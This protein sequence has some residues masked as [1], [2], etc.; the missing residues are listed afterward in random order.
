MDKV[1]TT[2]DTA[3]IDYLQ[4]AKTFEAFLYRIATC[5]G[6]ADTEAAVL[7]EEICLQG[8]KNFAGQNEGLT[9]RLWLSKLMIKSCIFTISSRLFSGSASAILTSCRCPHGYLSASFRKLPLSLQTIYI[10]VHCTGFSESE[11]ALLLNRTTQQVKEQ[12]A[13]ATIRLQVR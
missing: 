2:F 13:K 10:M 5:L 12:L 7:A 9:M 4:E 1:F 3:S 6:L 8:G 11:V